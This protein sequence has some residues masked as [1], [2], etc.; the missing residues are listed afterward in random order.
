M[1]TQ[2]TM[3]IPFFEN[4]KNINKFCQ[5]IAKKLKKMSPTDFKYKLMQTELEKNESIFM[6]YRIVLENKIRLR[7]INNFYRGL[8]D[9]LISK[10]R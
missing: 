5:R 7:N 8:I 2:A 10:Y 4:V 3:T 1:E 9:R 6:S